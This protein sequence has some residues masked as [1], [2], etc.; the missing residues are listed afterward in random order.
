LHT[1]YSARDLKPEL[2][3]AHWPIRPKGI[4]CQAGFSVAGTRVST[5][6]GR[7]GKRWNLLKA[8]FNLVLFIFS[9]ISV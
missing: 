4:G 2:A 3:E 7:K 6:V 8:S 5:L 1:G 9:F